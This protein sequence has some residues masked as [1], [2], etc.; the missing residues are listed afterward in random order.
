MRSDL[1]GRPLRNTLVTDFFGGVAQAE[2]LP[3]LHT[4]R[5]SRL[6]SEEAAS[7][8]TSNAFLALD[9][10]NVSDILSS[11]GTLDAQAFLTALG[12]GPRPEAGG[13]MSR[14]LRTWFS[15]LGVLVM[16]AWVASR[17]K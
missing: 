15:S 17:R 6:S 14:K 8:S 16:V 5:T 11:A 10:T 12:D 4:T 2:V 1:F 7:A 3:P 9:E 13:T